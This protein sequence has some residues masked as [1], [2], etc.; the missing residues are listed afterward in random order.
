MG[1]GEATLELGYAI[2]LT[3]DLIQELRAY[4]VEIASRHR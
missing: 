3:D 2:A 4:R 1:S